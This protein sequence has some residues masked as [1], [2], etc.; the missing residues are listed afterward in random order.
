MAEIHRWLE[1]ALNPMRGHGLVE[2]MAEVHRWS[3][4]ALNPMR[5]HVLVD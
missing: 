5:G 1:Q 2:C 4:Q 3:E